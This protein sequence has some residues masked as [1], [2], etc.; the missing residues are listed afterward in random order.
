MGKQEQAFS[1][2]II[3]ELLDTHRSIAEIKY[4]YLKIVES[5]SVKEL[6]KTELK[7]LIIELASS[8]NRFF[9]DLRYKKVNKFNIDDVEKSIENFI[10]DAGKQVRK[11]RK[12]GLKLASSRIH[13]DR[14]PAGETE[15]D[16]ALLSSRVFEEQ[17]LEKD[18]LDYLNTIKSFLVEATGG[19]EKVKA[20]NK[21]AL[22]AQALIRMKVRN[23]VETLAGYNAN[24]LDILYKVRCK[25]DNV[26]RSGMKINVLAA[27]RSAPAVLNHNELYIEN[28]G[29]D[30]YSISFRDR[31]VA[32]LL[33]IMLVQHLQGKP[34]LYRGRL[35]GWAETGPNRVNFL[36]E[37][38]HEVSGIEFKDPIQA[39]VAAEFLKKAEMETIYTQIRQAGEAKAGETD[40]LRQKVEQEM[41]QKVSDALDEVL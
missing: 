32:F 4:L 19:A 24:N 15:I 28:H 29:N 12:N 8:L 27:S 34:P 2:K 33:E 7:G 5:H 22:A 41:K 3:R 35:S 23:F 9:N 31:S 6:A 16:S 14:I 38:K 37:D 36:L 39:V 18:K 10:K 25:V 30:N 17:A 13:L 1:N 26:L 40:R 20:K 11:V 21:A